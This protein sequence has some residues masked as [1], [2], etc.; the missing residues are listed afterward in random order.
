MHPVPRECARQQ[1]A[2]DN[3]LP[4]PETC[5]PCHAESTVRVTPTTK[6]VMKFSHAAHA[7]M[8]TCQGCHRPSPEPG[9]TSMAFC[10]GCHNKID[11]TDSCMKCHLPTQQLKPATHTRQFIETHSNGKWDTRGCAVCHGKDF[12]C[13]GCH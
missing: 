4:K 7:Q 3:L 6:F 5:K 9:F 8:L 2:S 10:I 13:Q 1:L 12:S 11:M